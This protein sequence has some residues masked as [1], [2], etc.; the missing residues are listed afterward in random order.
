MDTFWQSEALFTCVVVYVSKLACADSGIPVM[1]CAHQQ[2][3]S[4][5]LVE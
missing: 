1:N 5:I 4:P 3:Q 2:R